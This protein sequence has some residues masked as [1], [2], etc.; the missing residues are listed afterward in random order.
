[1]TQFD[2]VTHYLAVFEEAERRVRVH[3]QID[4]ARLAARPGRKCELPDGTYFYCHGA[5]I[6]YKLDG[7]ELD[8]DFEFAD[9]ENCVPIFDSWRLT[10]FAKQFGS[11][12]PTLQSTEAVTKVLD[13]LAKEGH[14]E[15][16]NSSP[17][18][19]YRLVK[20]LKK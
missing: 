16:T 2:L 17:P 10:N 13:S 3:F 12:Y 19:M 5:G 14:I 7:V 15:A 4:N 6:F 20:T 9:G 18:H 8:I 11:L 1:M